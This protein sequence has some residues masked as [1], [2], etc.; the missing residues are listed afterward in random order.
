AGQQPRRVR[1]G[2]TDAP[3]AVVDSQRSHPESVH[4]HRCYNRERMRTR[5]LVA[6]I[7]A[8]VA[9]VVVIALT[10]TS[11]FRNHRGPSKYSQRLVILGFDGMDPALVS[12]WM[13]EG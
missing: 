9:V 3:S 2:E 13:R 1:H 4:H 6:A 11:L 7:L 8:V 10:Q 12:R 5:S